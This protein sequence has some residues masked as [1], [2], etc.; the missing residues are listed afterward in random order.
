MKAHS[1]ISTNVAL[2]P[3]VYKAFWLGVSYNAIKFSVSKDGPL[4]FLNGSGS[5][6]VSG[7]QTYARFAF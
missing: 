3:H 2:E 1:R 5:Y 6:R 4:N 7:A